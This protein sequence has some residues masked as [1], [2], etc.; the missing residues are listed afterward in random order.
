MKILPLQ[1]RKN[2]FNY[3]QV[4]RTDKKAK[5][6]LMNKVIERAL[7]MICLI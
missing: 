3:T 4:A 1:I 7:L 2:G 6:G 5:D